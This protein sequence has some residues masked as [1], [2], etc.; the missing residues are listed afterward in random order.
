M[1]R[2]TH[3]VFGPVPSRRLGR[4]LGVDLVPHKT[5]SYDCAYCQLGPTT[6][7]TLERGPFVSLRSV[8]GELRSKL[9]T[10]IAP[11]YITLSGSGEPTLQ[12]GLGALI[13]GIRRM[14]DRPVAV[15]T[16]G[17]L[18]WRQDVRSE[19]QT[20]DLVI[21]SLDAGDAAMFRR[22]NRPH[23]DLEFERMVAGLVAFRRAFPGQLWLE[24]FLLAGLTTTD[25]QLRKIRALLDAIGPDRIQLN[26]VARPPSEHGAR[27]ASAAAL[28]HATRVLGPRAEVIAERPAAD[29]PDTVTLQVEE[30]LALLA[31]RPCTLDDMAAGLQTHR[32][33]VAKQVEQL[34]RSQ[35]IVSRR[36]GRRVYYQP[37]PGHVESGGLTPAS[38]GQ[39]A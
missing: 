31:R 9:A 12:A 36:Y 26:T 15:L 23:P 24:V 25:D 5:C 22:V 14:T 7:R 29:T 1:Q 13:A 27:A 35:T 20:A 4:S 16:N 11:D 3:Y 19:L 10:G 37:A 21:P 33:G 2:R 17:S 18:L 8:L 38:K 28:A 30:I 6:N 39:R 32:L 34:L